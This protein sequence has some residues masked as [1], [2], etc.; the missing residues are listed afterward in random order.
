VLF[1][2][3]AIGKIN[4]EQT[5]CTIWPFYLA[6]LAALAAVIYLPAISLWLPGL[7]A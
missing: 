2:S 4:I 5:V 7:F 3:C 6:L 1:V